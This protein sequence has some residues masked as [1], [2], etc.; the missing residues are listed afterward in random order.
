MRDNLDNG[1]PS[2]RFDRVDGD[3]TGAN[4]FD[5]GED[6]DKVKEDNDSDAEW[7]GFSKTEVEA[8]PDLRSDSP[9]RRPQ[10]GSGNDDVDWGAT[11]L[12]PSKWDEHLDAPPKWDPDTGSERTSGHADSNHAGQEEEVE[13]EDADPDDPWK[14]RLPKRKKLP[15]NA[16]MTST[17]S[18][19]DARA[20]S[21]NETAEIDLERLQSELGI[22][23]RNLDE[24]YASRRSSG[25]MNKSPSLSANAAAGAG[26]SKVGAKWS[27]WGARKSSDNNGTGRTSIE[28]VKQPAPATTTAVSPRSSLTGT[29]PPITPAADTTTT[30]IEGQPGVSRFFRFGK[31]RPGNSGQTG[32]DS[33]SSD[34]RS[35]SAPISPV[36]G[37]DSTVN[38]S[39]NKAVEITDDFS[40]LENFNSERASSSQSNPSAYDASGGRRGSGSGL[41]GG[42]TGTGKNDDDNFSQQQRKPWFWNRTPVSPGGHRSLRDGGKV[43]DYSAEQEEEQDLD[44][45]FSVFQDPPASITSAVTTPSSSGLSSVERR[46]SLRESVQAARAKNGAAITRGGSSSSNRVT[47]TPSPSSSS[48]DPFAHLS[49]AASS[50]RSSASI[51]P[52]DPLDPLAELT[53]SSNITGRVYKDKPF[54]SPLNVSNR[55]TPPPLAPPPASGVPRSLSRTMRNVSPAPLLAPPPPLS[56]VSR[57][58]SAQQQQ[59]PSL[60]DDLADLDLSGGQSSQNTATGDIRSISAPVTQAP[61]PVRPSNTTSTTTNILD[62]DFGDF[63]TFTSA[64]VST[65]AAPQQSLANTLSPPQ[66]ASGPMKLAQGHTKMPGVPSVN[67]TS[68]TK[69]DLSFFDSL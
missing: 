26:T 67:A 20:A 4:D 23:I 54:V 49:A 69:D 8:L 56:S 17:R 2:S 39:A 1:N 11:N 35:T 66:K 68:G 43:V 15:N 61:T 47:S 5:E 48:V 63:A 32:A 3:R 64:P 41:N 25:E 52:F 27:L 12:P 50:I 58:T 31:G 16:R 51:D 62:D 24:E 45:V 6:E 13:L 59:Q 10:G 55:A 30:S 19:L 57:R 34:K 53:Q 65:S 18:S 14:P 44:K 7:G 37:D 9:Q 29:T 46:P 36:P 38:A 28:G 22:Q 40:Q 42:G 60:L 21:A 33:T